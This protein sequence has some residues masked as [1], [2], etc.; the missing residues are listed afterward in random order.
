MMSI[1]PPLPTALVECE[2]FALALVL[3]LVA[4]GVRSVLFAFGRDEKLVQIRL[5]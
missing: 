3:A 5:L 2:L 4:E 1:L